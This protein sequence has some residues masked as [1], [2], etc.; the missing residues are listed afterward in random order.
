MLGKHSYLVSQILFAYIFVVAG[1][2]ISFLQVLFLPLSSFKF[3]QKLHSTL[4]YLHWSTLIAHAQWV[5]NLKVNIWARPEEIKRFKLENSIVVANHKYQPD[6]LSLWVV[7]EHFNVLQNFKSMVKHSLLK[8][9]V[10]GWQ[11]WLNDYVLVKRKLEEDR[12]TLEKCFQRYAHCNNGQFWLTVFCEGTRFT[13]KK[14]DVSVDYARSKSLQPLKHHLMPR[15]RGFTMLANGMR[16][17]VPAVFDATICFDSTADPTLLDL[18]NG[19][20]I[21]ADILFRRLDMDNIPADEKESS[22]F[23]MKVYYEKDNLCEF[24]QENKRFP[25]HEGENYK[26]Y[27]KVSIP[28]S[29][30]AF[31]V[32]CIWFCLLVL[33]VAYLIVTK[34]SLS[35]IIITLLAIFSTTQAF[36]TILSSGK[37]QSTYGQK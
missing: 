19:K 30:R 29:T 7:G 17:F 16:K 23:L 8:V 28:K 12:N 18:V 14:H 3:H 26:E 9:P 31:V 25:T 11:F 10:I 21:T 32:F 37:P 5:C 34:G 1:C 13:K 33:P 20:P 27:V 22:D 35:Y 2:I 4:T 36:Q 6:W 15:T 24:H